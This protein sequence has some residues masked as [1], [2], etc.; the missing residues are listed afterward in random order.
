MPAVAASTSSAHDPVGATAGLGRPA[1]WLLLLGLWSVPP[2]VSTASFVLT[3][4]ATQASLPWPRFLWT[5]LTLWL[6]WVLLPPLVLR[7][8]RRLPFEPGRRARAIA[9]HLA[10]GLA[11]GSLFFAYVLGRELAAGL[12]LA[13]MPRPMLVSAYLQVALLHAAVYWILLLASRAVAYHQRNREREASLTR[14]RLQALKAQV[15]PHFLFNTLNAISSLMEDDVAAARRMM[16]RLSDLLRESLSGSGAQEVRLDEELGLLRLYL[17]IEQ[18]RFQ[19]RLR[20]DYRIDPGVGDL[21]V[22]HLLL[23]PLAE[24][25]IR[26]GIARDSRAGRLEIAA[27][28]NG[29]RL[30][31]EIVD[32]GPGLDGRRPE[33]GMGLG[34]TRPRLRELYGDSARLELEP[35][36]PRG[37][38]AWIELPVRRDSA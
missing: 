29:E 11:I 22:P 26:H 1:R 14:A 36:D 7:L 20:I 19:D 9:A 30:R 25:A 34:I 17:D 13:S 21:L 27:Q 24:N 33:D 18:Q 4:D 16:S 23:Q 38:R 35:A 10:I 37:C 3:V 6:P 12:E 5:H 32:D 28:R 15:H 31:L 8:G 2:L